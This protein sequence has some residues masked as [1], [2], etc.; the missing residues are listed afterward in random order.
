[1]KGDSRE[2]WINDYLD[3]VGTIIVGIIVIIMITLA[4]LYIHKYDE[5][6]LKIRN[7][8]QEQ[9]NKYIYNDGQRAHALGIPPEA[10]PY[11]RKYDSAKIWLDGYMDSK[12]SNSLEK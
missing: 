9:E 2:I 7:A 12:E 11:D 5:E 6:Q 8:R 10:N 4:T 3:I 1:V